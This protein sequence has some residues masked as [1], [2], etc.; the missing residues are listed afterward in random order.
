MI[1]YFSIVQ[2]IIIVNA[3]YQINNSKINKF[4]IMFDYLLLPLI[5]YSAIGHIFLSKRIAKSI[6]WKSSPF[7]NELGYFTLSIFI[8][9]LYASFNNYSNET[10]R[11]ISYIWV[12]FIIMAAL[13][14]TKEIIYD[15]NYS[16]NNIYPIFIT[17]ITSGFVFYY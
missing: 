9:G 16:F 2:L 6:G 11:S 7:Q 13:N 15:N 3:I 12:L 14:H 4:K 8:I 17:I 5:L 10:L 1:Q